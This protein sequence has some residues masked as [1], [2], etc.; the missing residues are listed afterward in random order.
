MAL[1]KSGP[2]GVIYLRPMAMF[3]QIIT[4]DPKTARRMFAFLATSILGMMAIGIWSIILRDW[5]FL[6]IW[7]VCVADMIGTTTRHYNV[8]WPGSRFDSLRGF[9]RIHLSEAQW[10]LVGLVFVVVTLV[11]L[12]VLGPAREIISVFLGL[13]CVVW[14]WRLLRAVRN[15]GWRGK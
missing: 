5:L 4:T 15:E 12:L 6:F 1:H 14:L 3:R 13:V 9:P 7:A 10:I 8:G 2:N 11:P